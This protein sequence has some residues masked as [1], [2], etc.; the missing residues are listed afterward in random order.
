MSA[1]ISAL[2]RAGLLDEAPDNEADNPFAVF[3]EWSSEADEKAY[4]D[5]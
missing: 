2:P 3:S 1:A 4:A 5:L